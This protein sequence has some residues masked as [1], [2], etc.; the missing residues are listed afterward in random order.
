V[1][2]RQQR[3]HEL[4]RSGGP[5]TPIG[6]RERPAPAPPR[7][8]PRL[9]LASAVAVIAAAVLVVLATVAHLGGG[10]TVA[11]AARPS[12]LA[13]T[14]PAPVPDARHPT[15]LRA[16]FAGLDYPNWQRQFGW[17]ATGRRSDTI[18]GR[19]TETVFYQ[20]THHRIGYTVVSREALR[21]PSGAERIEANGLQMRAYKD[22]RRDVVTFERGG[23]TCVLAGVVHRRSTLV[24]LAS[25]KAGGAIA[26]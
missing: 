21:P 24:K 23:R 25:W 7:Y 14:A 11:E 1:S 8:R 3:V 17:R 6:V 16:R 2:A 26:F 20:H 5:A 15:L 12:G 13:A 4:L 22:G 19:R 9:A 10:P 18:A